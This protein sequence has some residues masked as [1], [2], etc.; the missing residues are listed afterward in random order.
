MLSTPERIILLLAA[1]ISITLTF[2]AARR[3]VKTIQ[4]GTGKFSWHYVG[5]NITRAILETISLRPTFK[6][7]FIPDLLHAMVAWGFMFFLITNLIDLVDGFSVEPLTER[8]GFAGNFID[9]GSDL[10]SI[11]VL[12]GMTGL[13]VRRF[14]LRPADLQTRSDILIS[15][16]ANKGIKRDS[17]IVGVFIL[18]HVGSRFLGQA[19]RLNG[20]EIDPW[21]PFA[22][23]V[24]MALGSFSMQDQVVL[25]HVLFWLALGTILAFLPY[26]LY[27]KHLHLIATPVSFLIKPSKS[28]LAQLSIINFDDEDLEIFGASKLEDLPWEQILDSYACIMCYRCQE[29]CPAYETGKVL[30][31][32]AMEINK[33]Y[34]LNKSGAE[35]AKGDSSSNLLVKSAIPEDAIW[36]CT[37][38][39]ACIEIC[40][41]NNEPMIDIIEIRRSLVL[42]ENLYP[43]QFTGCFKGMERSSNPWGITPAER[44]NWAEDLEIPTIQQNPEPEILWWVG[45]AP[46]A[47]EHA[48]NTARSFARILTRAGISF[49]VLGESENCTG[50]SA[51]R[52]GNEYLFYELANTNVNML[53]ELGITDIVTTCPHCFHTLKNE[54]PSFGGNYRVIHH[55]ELLEQLINKNRIQVESSF[56]KSSTYHDPCYLGRHNRLYQSPRELIKTAGIHLAE[57]KRN[58]DNSFCCGAG[59]A[60]M[61]KEEEAGFERISANRYREA[62]DTRCELIVTACPFCAIMLD[63]AGKELE[64]QLAI[65]DVAEI[66]ENSMVN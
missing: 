52:A 23:R 14:L 32:A 15:E 51:R 45:C 36:A 12:M 18:I 22:S 43:E 28:T 44:M 54:Y 10:F 66:V 31:P 38:C 19:V 26:F 11:V 34:L 6:V 4:R 9:L 1:S 40:P 7:R 33:R 8:M 20:S 56:E 50:D 57:M 63:D 42:M 49:A 39:G 47:D 24:S 5:E 2:L 58:R 25:A 48:R 64:E 17:L 37:T 41:V 53:N 16:H 27:S 35:I 30:S 60:Q 62:S 55:S 21:Q 65:L 61:W 3:I 59:G 13:L 46:C 29:A